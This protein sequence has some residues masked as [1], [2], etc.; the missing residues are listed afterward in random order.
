MVPGAGQRHKLTGGSKDSPPCAGKD[1]QIWPIKTMRWFFRS[2]T[3]Q[4]QGRDPDCCLQNTVLDP[5]R[6]RVS[7]KAVGIFW[8]ILKRSDEFLLW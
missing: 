5:H 6:L 2:C 8:T 4:A 3:K 1:H 7:G